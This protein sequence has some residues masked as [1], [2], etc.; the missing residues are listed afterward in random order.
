MAHHIENGNNLTNNVALVTG[1]GNSVQANNVYV[2]GTKIKNVKQ[3]TP[4]PPA[5][6][7]PDLW[8]VPPKN[9]NFT[10]RTEL[11]EQMKSLYNHRNSTTIIT[12]CHGLGGIGK[13]QLALEFI[14]QHY[15][16]YNGVIWFDAES[17]Q[18]LQNSYISLGRELNIIHD[19]EKKDDKELARKVKH[20]LEN[21]SHA[22]WLLVYDNAPN[23]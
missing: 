15:K 12:A 14:W 3:N 5:Q 20:W 8:N 16:K 19:D 1:E 17:S 11:I 10:G 6:H 13:T 7:L 23:Y 18:R 9:V 2:T 4:A 21:D 22:G